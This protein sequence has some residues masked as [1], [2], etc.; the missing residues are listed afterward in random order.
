MQN[1]QEEMEVIIESEDT[2]YSQ[3]KAITDLTTYPSIKNIKKRF[4]FKDQ[5]QSITNEFIIKRLKF[6]GD[7]LSDRGEMNQRELLGFISMA[8]LSGLSSKSPDGRFSNGY[9]WADF[10]AACLAANFDEARVKQWCKEQK[11]PYLGNDD[12]SD[13]IITKDKRLQKILGDDLEAHREGSSSLTRGK[14]DS[15]IEH[16]QIID[17]FDNEPEKNNFALDDYK[18]I[19]YHGKTWI[20][21][22]CEGG[23]T[24]W[25]YKN[26]LT[27]SIVRFFSRK[28]LT[29]LRIMRHR[30]LERDAKN[31]VTYQ[32]KRETLIIEW[33]GANDLI[34]VNEKPTRREAE[35]VVKARIDNI[36]KLAHNGYQN[37]VLFN[38]PDLSLTPRFQARSKEEQKEASECCDF[39]N[40]LLQDSILELSHEFPFANIHLFDINSQF[41]E[42]YNNP[43]KYGF[44]PTKMTIPY[45]TSEEYQNSNGVSPS[46]GFFFWDDVHPTADTHAL[47]ATRFYDWVV[48]RFHFTEP[49]SLTKQLISESEDG[50][51]KRYRTIYEYEITKKLNKPFGC[52][53]YSHFHYQDANLREVIEHAQNGG[54]R[55]KSILMRLGVLDKNGDPVTQIPAVYEAM[56]IPESEEAILESYRTIYEYEITE[57]LNKPF[58]CIGYSHFNYQ[59]ASLSEVIE[60]AQ[61]GGSRSKRILIQLGVLDKNG[62]RLVE[63]PA[64]HP[65]HN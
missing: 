61:N 5:N 45:T 19:T 48:N 16:H 23:L 46:T 42:M 8:H 64:A 41:K 28:I 34:T 12:F 57:K 10:F 15:A 6:I 51:L 40:N 43:E 24:A 3:D 63:I 38:L 18:G 55:T 58:G 4:N 32:E 25:D 52:L 9:V 39:L 13:G 14:S 53:G 31:D 2:D 49:D 11:L 26:T 62:D 60:H 65:L 22:F 21:N 17:D 30:L 56:K 33:S 50:I 47:L 20:E 44:D 1:Q 27:D 29:N 59:D 36:R 37:F 7:S 35:R 54:H